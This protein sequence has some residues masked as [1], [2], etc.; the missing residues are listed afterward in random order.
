MNRYTPFLVVALLAVS[1]LVLRNK[2]GGG[3]P[4]GTLLPVVVGELPDRVETLVN[5]Q[6]FALD[7]L[8]YSPLDVQVEDGF[9]YVSDAPV[10]LLRF[11]SSGRF[12][13]QIGTG[14]GRG[15]GELLGYTD[16]LVQGDY[17]WI[18]SLQSRSLSKYKLD[19]THISSTGTEPGAYR[20]AK[21]G[22]SLVVHR[23]DPTLPLLRIG[24]DGGQ[25]AGF[26]G[27]IA[28]QGFLMDV[29]G[30][31]ASTYSGK[32]IYAATYASVLYEFDTSGNI[33]R[34]IPTLD[35]V[36]F[37]TRTQGDVQRARSSDQEVFVRDVAVDDG[38]IYVNTLY[39]RE[40]RESVIDLYDYS[41]G[42]Y[43]R[44]LRL[45][46]AIRKM[47]VDKGRVYAVRDTSVVTFDSW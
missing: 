12:V 5:P 18:A 46:Y 27:S 17:V 37:P 14:P 45:P 44:S 23:P 28:E 30:Y 29:S 6:L 3:A 47:D 21:P 25:G 26:G 4:A 34:V 20:L 11:D 8:L 32:F 10:R 16:F 38:I 7:T 42:K 41:S 36:P 35:G 9:V 33:E 31:L 22:D 39:R 24:D 13:N 40:P 43:M 19:G 15:P 1:V 2:S